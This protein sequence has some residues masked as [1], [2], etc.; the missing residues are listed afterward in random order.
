MPPISTWPGTPSPPTDTALSALSTRFS[1]KSESV[2][3]YL[4]D[5]ATRIYAPQLDRLF[6]TFF[7]QL[8]FNIPHLSR[9]VS[10]R[11]RTRSPGRLLRS[12]FPLQHEELATKRSRWESRVEGQIGSCPLSLSPVGHPCLLSPRWS[13]STSAADPRR[14]VY[15][16]VTVLARRR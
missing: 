13:A 1:F 11:S 9:F 2:N 8:T 12:C 14:W 3:E 16:Y 6:I 10:H 7:N 15:Q 4:D 5:F